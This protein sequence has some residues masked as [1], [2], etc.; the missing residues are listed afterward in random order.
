[1]ASSS[2][3]MSSNGEPDWRKM[4]KQALRDALASR[5]LDTSGLRPSLIQR[6]ENSAKAAA[7]ALATSISCESLKPIVETS[8]KDSAAKVES[9]RGSE[10]ITKSLKLDNQAISPHDASAS[11]SEEKKEATTVKGLL[12]KSDAERSNPTSVTV[13]GEQSVSNSSQ[14]SDLEKKRLRAER[15]GVGLQVSEQEKLALRAE[16]F[17]GVGE[18]K[19]LIGRESESEKRK[20]RASRF[21]IVDEESKKKARLDRFSSALKQ[22]KPTETDKMKARAARSELAYPIG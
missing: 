8:Q 9:K 20:Q 7:Q 12:S 14:L 6:L 1:M 2:V 3:A 15:F 18:K 5:G 16:R 21:G 11:V 22:D 13:K 17:S 4:N 19:N 10:E